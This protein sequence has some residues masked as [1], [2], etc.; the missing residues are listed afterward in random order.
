VRIV[1]CADVHLDGQP[2][3]GSRPIQGTE[4]PKDGPRGRDDTD[5]ARESHG[6]AV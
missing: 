1:A 4:V 3:S 5:L 2:S 6:A